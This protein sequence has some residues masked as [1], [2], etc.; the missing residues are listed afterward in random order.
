MTNT[1]Q[2][3][4]FSRRGFIA[5]AIIVG[6]IVLA[7]IIV[8]VTSLNRGSGDNTAQPT[9]AP[10]TS[11]EPRGNAADKSACGL[12]GYEESSSL[13]TAPGNE[14]ELVGTVAA[15]TAPKGAGPGVIKDGFRTCYSHTAEGALFAAVTYVALGSDSRNVPKLPELIEPGAGKDAAIAASGGTP[16]PSSARL[17][18]AGF[19]VN[20]FDGQEAVIDVAWAV[21]SQ[22]GALV[23][24]PT[25]LHWV[26][27]DWKIALSDEGQPPFASSPLENLGGYIPWSGV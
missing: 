18:V 15:P 22:G 6:I 4:P 13:T 26:D 25:V 10:S 3:N 17:Q 20:S 19:K 7:A 9:T 14:W 8:L 11:A 23:S 24:F 21:T 5:A 12:S 1:E 2:R 27:G 16:T